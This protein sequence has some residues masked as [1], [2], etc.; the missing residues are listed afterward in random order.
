MII[1]N[2]KVNRTKKVWRIL[3]VIFFWWPLMNCTAQQNDWPD[4]GQILQ[5]IQ[6]P[7]F[8]NQVFPITEFG[9][10][11]DGSLSTEAIN[12]AIKK[13][14]ESGGGKVIVPAGIFH[15][16]A[17]HLLSN[18][19]LYLEEGAVLSFS[20]NPDDYL[21]LVYTRW[22]GIDCYNFSPL[23][24]AY[25]QTNIA[26]SGKGTIQGNASV[27]N[28][29]IWKGKPDFGW[30]DTLPSQLLS[31]ARPALDTY[32]ANGVPVEERQ[33][34]SGFYL[35]PQFVNFVQCGRILIE[36][37][38]IENSPFWVIHP[39]FCSNMV[40]RGVHINSLGPNNDG[41]DPESCKD[42]LIEDCYFNCGDDCI[43][44]K[45][46]RNE[47]GR[48]ANKPSENILVRNCTM[49]NGH[50][51]VVI[52]SEISGGARNIF[53]EDCIMD[54]PELDRAIRIKTNSNRGGII[55]N[56][57]V[58]NVKI[59]RV[60]EAV[61]RI[62]CNYYAKQE[63]HDKY[64]PVVRN[65]NLTNMECE[66]SK[67]GILLEGINGQNS[68]DN[69]HISDSKFNGVKKENSISHAS[70]VTFDHVYINNKLFSLNSESK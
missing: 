16:G 8:S 63:G 22:E 27:N 21:P 44:I 20:T 25:K 5:N 54:S 68:I 7:V 17:I 39:M 70:N 46:G 66:S 10:K 59:G 45:S 56:I 6:E 60:K 24:Y 48:K 30:N 19:N 41:C 57:Y 11:P 52:G 62:N 40:V 2:Y 64:Y 65:V 43:A 18:V 49:D 38:T 36:G 26:L 4:S 51:G 33:M 42:I 3:I 9:A 34:G 15:T 23:I 29:W 37:I 53:V 12:A 69:I 61:L 28:W 1:K 67:Y 32:N 58:K 14:N 47:D 55:E 31:H 50:G 35:R 13:C